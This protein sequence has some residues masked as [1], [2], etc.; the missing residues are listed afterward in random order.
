[1]AET[2]D[3]NAGRITRDQIARASRGASDHRARRTAYEYAHARAAVQRSR[4]VSADV[5]A[6]DRD[7]AVAATRAQDNVIRLTRND[8][9]RLNDGAT[10]QSARTNVGRVDLYAADRI[11]ELCVAGRVEANDVAL[12]DVVRASSAS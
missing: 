11:G 3:D 5:V 10:N 9:A 4:D 8:V 2:V 1:M 7:A 12:N 6:L